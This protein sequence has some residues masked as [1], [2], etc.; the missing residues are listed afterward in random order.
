MVTVSLP[1][2]CPIRIST[3]HRIFAPTRRFSQLITSFF[4]SKSLGILHVPFSPF[5][6][7]FRLPGLSLPG[8]LLK[9]RDPQGELPGCGLRRCS[10]G[11][12]FTLYSF[13]SDTQVNGS[14]LTALRLRRLESSRV[15]RASIMSMSSLSYRSPWQS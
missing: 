12:G 14:R 15:S 6:N 9:S 7:V 5:L 2:G 11:F 1:P 3:A 10:F 13:F 8:T 4:A